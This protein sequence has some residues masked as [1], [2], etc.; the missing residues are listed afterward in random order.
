MMFI[1]SLFSGILSSMNILANRWNDFSFNLN[2][3]YMISLM[4]SWMYFFMSLI[5]K[6]YQMTLISGIITIMTIYL[7]RNQIFINAKQY[8]RSMVL[9]H[10][11]AVF[12]TKQLIKKNLSLNPELSKLANGIIKTQ[13]EEIKLMKKLINKK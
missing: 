12:M 5:G 7:I 1:A 3:I 13:E 4:I 9:H 8:L 11:V 6:N 2:E 10:S